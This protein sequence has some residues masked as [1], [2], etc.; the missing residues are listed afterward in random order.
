MENMK[1]RVKEMLENTPAAN[2]VE[3]ILVE[4]RCQGSGDIISYYKSAPLPD[5]GFIVISASI[6][7]YL[8]AGDDTYFR[9]GL[10]S[11]DVKSVDEMDHA[12]PFFK[13]FHFLDDLPDPFVLTGPQALNF[14]G[15]N[16]LVLAKNLRI[17]SEVVPNIAQPYYATFALLIHKLHPSI[18]DALEFGQNIV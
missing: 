13:Y 14:Y 12:L 11:S 17:V 2:F 8:A 4:C 1:S 15:L 5:N 7:S 9:V 10:S 3:R 18:L 6:V 16:Q